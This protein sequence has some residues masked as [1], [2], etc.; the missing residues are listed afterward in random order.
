MILLFLV[1]FILAILIVLIIIYFIYKNKIQ[2]NFSIN[3]HSDIKDKDNDK[4][5]AKNRECSGSKKDGKL[6]SQEI[7]D[8]E[9]NWKFC[10]DSLKNVSRSFNIVIKQLDDET[11]NVV[12]IF[13]LVLRGLDTI[14]D[15][16]SIPIE[17]KKQILL[18]FYN[19]I[20]NDDYSV[21]YGDK[22][23]YRILMK[24]FY[25]VN[26][27]YKQ[28]HSKY[29]DVIKN[30]TRE[31]AKGMV[32]F[33]DKPYIETIKE[34]DS[35]C[36]YVAGLVGIGLSQIFTI[37]GLEFNDLT[38]YDKLSNSM[39]LFLQKTNIIRDIK[40]DY[41]EKRYWWPNDIVN[42]Y[43]SSMHHV[44]GNK[45]EDYNNS[46]NSNNSN[47]EQNIR[48]ISEENIIT[49]KHTDLLN[50]MIMNAL[51]HIPDSIEYLSLVKHNNNFKFCAI[52]QVVAVQ[53]LASIFNNQNVFNKTEKLNKTTLA[54]I[55]IDVNEIN[56]VL[57]FYI[58]AVE[59]IEIKIIDSNC[60]N[61]KQYSHQLDKIKAYIMKYII[62]HSKKPVTNISLTKVKK[63]VISTIITLFQKNILYPLSNI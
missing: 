45:S 21:E 3:I 15:D 19:D 17:D 12:C 34:Y 5:F 46:N 6:D 8:I 33:L 42:K 61:S 40:E 38:K 7:K 36:H 24:N 13:Y 62:E 44:F 58:D 56:S 43:F 37:S 27:T 57:Q 47:G 28:L 54:R 49:E 35:Y 50:E 29:R 52:P 1:Y 30:T 53:T 14:E 59:K 22:L 23:E 51:E 39:G 11:M 10:F 2:F 60:L 16:M 31:M 26:R 55:F 48:K 9:E 32:E 63:S 41:D 4:E 25:K 18:N 20:E